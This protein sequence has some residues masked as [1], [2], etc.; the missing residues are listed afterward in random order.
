MK[1]YV[2]ICF[3]VCYRV[4]YLSYFAVGYTETILFV[5]AGADAGIPKADFILKQRRIGLA[6]MTDM[7]SHK[8]NRKMPLS[9]KEQ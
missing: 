5:W 2:C 7:L 6:C 1:G 9:A 3:F 4:S 8:E